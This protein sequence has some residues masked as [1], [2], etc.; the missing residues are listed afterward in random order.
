M[1]DT[2]DKRLVISAE[3]NIKDNGGAN[4]LS[5]DTAKLNE[6]MESLAKSFSNVEKSVEQI[7]NT[8][9]SQAN[10][11]KSTMNEIDK[12]NAKYK[13]N[14]ISVEEY[15][16][17][18]EKLQNTLSNKTEDESTKDYQ[19]NLKKLIQVEK[20]LTTL[21]KQEA[22]V[23]LKEEKT[24]NAQ[25]RQEAKETLAQKKKA[26]QDATA[27]YRQS[28]NERKASSKQLDN[29]YGKNTGLQDRMF[30]AALQYSGI[31]AIQ[32]EFEKLSST[33]VD[34]QY[35]TINNQRLMGD[36]SDSLRDSLTS[37]AIEIANATG[38]MI[39]DAQEIQGA[40]IRI[41]EQYA[42]SPE[43]LDK[44]ANTTAKF[45]NV[46]EIE[47][48]ESAVK[49]L[50]STLMQFNLNTGD[51]ANNLDEVANKFAY[52]ADVTSIGTADE[53][54]ESV[55][56][57]GANIK[58][59]KGDLDDAIVL[60]SI[61]GDKLAKNG[62]EAGNTLN[63]FTAYMQR[64]KSLE[65]F[66]E[67]ADQLGNANIS[68][69]E[70]EKGLKSYKDSLAAI[71]EAYA[72]L[73]A[74][75]DDVGINK[76]V[77]ALGATRQR[78]GAFAVLNALTE[79]VDDNGTTALDQYYNML[80]EVTLKGHYL[81]DQ[82]A[83]LMTSLKNQ[84]S[85]LVTAIQSVGVSFGNAGILNGVSMIT[86][87]FTSM[88][89]IVA[90]LPTPLKSL[91]AAFVAVKVGMAGLDKLGEAF[92]INERL[93]A[94]ING[95][96]VEQIESSNAIRKTTN[97]YLRQQEAM[98]NSA[99][100]TEKVSNAYLNQRNALETLEN[101][102]TQY[103]L[104]LRDGTI[105]HEEYNRGI[106]DSIGNYQS[107]MQSI[108]GTTT[109]TEGLTEAQKR[110]NFALNESDVAYN[111]NIKLR[112]ASIFQLAKER[113]A[114]ASNNGYKKASI[115]VD[116]AKNAV[117][118]ISALLK[119]KT[120]VATTSDTVA[121]TVNTV[122]TK[123]ATLA[124]SAFGVALNFV[125]HPLVL[126]TA[127]IT[128]L[129]YIFGASK[130]ETEKLNETIDEYKQ[131]ITD[132][133]SRV[134]EL[135]SK[136]R[137]SGLSGT[138][139]AELEYLETKLEHEKELLAVEEKKKSK[140]EYEGSGHLWWKE[141]GNK[142]R[143]NDE[144]K[145]FNQAID[146]AKTYSNL[147][148]SMVNTDTKYAQ[149]SKNLTDA[150]MQQVESA[151]LLNTWYE[152]LEYNLE[153]GTWSG[154]T[155]TK[156]QEQFDTLSSMKPQI[157][158][159]ITASENATAALDSINDVDFSSFKEEL[160]KISEVMDALNEDIDRLKEEAL[161][162][163]ELV[164]LANKYDGFINVIGKSAE[165][166]IAYLR[167]LKAEQAQTIV[168]SVDEQIKAAT[169]Q[170]NKATDDLQSAIDNNVNRDSDKFIVLQEEVEACI[171][172][173]AELNAMKEINIDIILEAEYGSVDEALESASRTVET[174]QGLVDEYNS[175]EGYLN[176][177]TIQSI[178]SVH[179]E[180]VKYLVKE[181]G[182]YKLNT[183]A[184]EDLEKAKKDEVKATDDLI[185]SIENQEN[186]INR[187]ST[188]YKTALKAS[189]DYA[190]NIANTFKGVEGADKF[191]QDLRQIN[192]DFIT[193]KTDIDSYNQSMKSLVDGLDF[194][195]VN[196]DLDT[197]DE[198]A[199]QMAQSQQAMFTS[200]ASSVSSY[201]QDA[202]VSLMHG[203]MQADEYVRTLQSSNS[204]LLQMYVESNNL[205]L[206][207]EGK[208]ANAAGD[209][210]EYANSLQNAINGLN[211]MSEATQF[212]QEHQA[213]LA[214]VQANTA[215]NM[216]NATWW[217]ANE[218]SS[219]YTAM[220]NDFSSLMGNMYTNNYAA[221][222]AIVQDVAN[223]TGLNTTDI[224]N[225]NGT[226]T[227]TAQ[228]NA[229]VMGSFTEATMNQVGGAVTT[230]A[231]AAGNV[232]SS[233]GDMIA[234]FD[235]TLTLTPT[236][237]IGADADIDLL[238]G[239]F[240]ITPTGSIGLTV[241][242]SGG[243][244]VS[245][246]ASSL[247][248][249][250]DAFSKINFNNFFGNIGSYRP[251]SYTPVGSSGL[252]QGSGYTP[253]SR[254]ASRPS[255]GTSAPYESKGSGNK[256]KSDAE[257][258]AEDAA[259]AAEEAAKAVQRI[260]ESYVKNVETMQ[261]RIANA[262]KKKYQEQYDERKKLLDK[263]HNDRIAQIQAEIDKING[264]TPQDKQSELERLRSKLEKWQAD[265]STLGKSKQKEYMD[266]IAELEKE[267]KIDELEQQMEDE[268]DR[269]DKLIDQDSEFYDAILKK[270]DQQMTDEMLYREANDMIRNGK[271]QEIT[272]LLTKYDANWSGWAS[273]MGQT[274]GEIIANEVATAIANY[275]DVKNGT[276]TPD[277]G[278]ETNKVTGG[279][280]SGS[281]SGGS[282]SS[283]SG[284]IS[285]GRKVRINDTNTGMYYASDSR[286]PSGSWRGYS[287]SY[288]VVN[289]AGGRVALSRTNS[290]NGA[291][292]WIDKN[293]VTA[294]A[295]G[296][297]VPKTT[298]AMLGE[299]GKER[300]LSARQTAAFDKFI[301]N[302]LPR[303]QR[304][305]ESNTTSIGGN[306]TNFNKEIMRI[307]VENVNNY[308]NAD[309]TN[310][311]DNMDRL[312]RKSL[313][314]VGVRRKL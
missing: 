301:Y 97:E 182:Q 109:A 245:K 27:A 24:Y 187:L 224:V 47:N 83:V 294:L 196:Q 95:A 231:Q 76:I 256:G 111:R 55:A 207:H 194:S 61:V 236:G 208:W 18:L 270:L 41:N 240:S 250:G 136:Q 132:T 218:N 206:N 59:M 12:L 15:R 28:I 309:V 254:P 175:N 307:E 50:N 70:G 43:L 286:S 217:A 275:L 232:I 146:S 212:L 126:I 298:F 189:N 313:Q 69:R 278:K 57:M 114:L 258:A 253:S 19:E 296:G 282:S 40:W 155:L 46:G 260:T 131:S 185:A 32:N 115:V 284:S 113:L 34:I 130:R 178:L 14:K 30:N 48:A 300:V 140:K 121:K 9:K 112:N 151:K 85:Q 65:L 23:R 123:A 51:V 183:L 68:L 308:N 152:Y 105:T 251:S 195:K 141:T 291:I 94:S 259:K 58:N 162:D 106:S 154:D 199:K 205:A 279:S 165:E 91:A 11:T 33:I 145:S 158:E 125:L 227:E 174:L 104:G 80:N 214:E 312:L 159:I 21:K 137:Q 122:A 215:N 92:K 49:L 221:W 264:E 74:Q 223:A 268:N 81:E 63:T 305:I 225:S 304:Q 248:T 180:Y 110:A 135:K 241:N 192:A 107:S 293:K 202:T 164:E 44:V 153:K 82:N 290:I 297:V 66:D 310:M 77:E 99:S 210:N 79:T 235:Y 198:N 96:T 2:N 67:L 209:V 184:L 230:A 295:S 242:G 4:Q 237:S 38:I 204:Q 117:E 219:A 303:L 277:G 87:A 168:D 138:E 133:T 143:I 6:T 98:F 88:L 177:S 39:T 116:K 78:A 56:K 10:A 306:V 281:S 216:V 276:I 149:Y 197:L 262:L 75:G 62:Q 3:L 239:K 220:A 8:F 53:F 244:S 190:D 228:G 233:L 156:A 285:N 93:F 35:N 238:K 288:Y 101:E 139:E 247:S 102:V 148:E 129:N 193:G 200:L 45:M 266:A 120:T 17:E 108:V 22:S 226:I 280:S 229:A 169:E 289:T 172:K 292:G 7:S 311:E 261:D 127:A 73:K 142:E 52:M 72:T 36:F 287:G 191:A 86:G 64:D 170:Y 134:D 166:Q 265:D 42:K 16:K 222:D 269:Y 273:L 157:D 188:E 272:D 25:V 160:E 13:S 29:L 128:G 186:G 147:L 252:G 274:A 213:I 5:Q 299:A 103:N 71:G 173:L 176:P 201:L 37:N 84:F 246:F 283:S 26:Y 163:V 302:Q 20:Q 271:I 267:I 167:K 161:S 249:F 263:E 257:K 255:G 1:A 179:P 89:N 243:D 54:A 90:D 150:N 181:N 211:S 234:S 118:T 31:R 119:G 144:I 100:V 203:E 314:K 171:E 60:T 124:T